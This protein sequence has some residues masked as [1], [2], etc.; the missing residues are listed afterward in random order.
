MNHLSKYSQ[1]IK[2]NN[3]E[4]EGMAKALIYGLRRVNVLYKLQCYME[5]LSVLD[6]YQKLTTGEIEKLMIL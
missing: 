6:K 4:E 5:C 3:E 1:P 2:N